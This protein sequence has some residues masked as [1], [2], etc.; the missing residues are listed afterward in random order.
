MVQ[1]SKRIL[2]VL[3][4]AKRHEN[5]AAEEYD[6]ARQQCQKNVF[7][8]R[9][10]E[11]FYRDY[12]QQNT[13][14]RTLRAEEFANS[15]LFLENLANVI[16]GQKN[17]VIQSERFLEEKKRVWNKHYLKRQSMEDLVTRY[18]QEELLALDKQDQKFIDEWVS[19]NNGRRN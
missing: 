3:D 19:Q 4:L 6:N 11:G 2:P 17:L 13:L 5:S 10:M 18:R 16:E 9:E 12:A 1:R 8:L 7:Q 14:S 15:R